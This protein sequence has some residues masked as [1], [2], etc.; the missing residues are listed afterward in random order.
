MFDRYDDKYK[1]TMEDLKARYYSVSKALLKGRGIENH[2]ILNFEY[3]ADY[4]RRRKHELEKYFL[5][6]HE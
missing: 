5:R 2:P 1:R 4:E 6:S 3:N